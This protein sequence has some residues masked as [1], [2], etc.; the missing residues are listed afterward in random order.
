[1]NN[2]PRRTRFY[3]RRIDN[4]LNVQKIVTIHYQELFKGYAYSRRNAR[5]LG[6][7]LYG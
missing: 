2:A 6:N 5:F 4:L 7:D 1:M 3:M